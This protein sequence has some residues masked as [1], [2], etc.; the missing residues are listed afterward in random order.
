MG[1]WKREKVKSIIYFAKSLD[2]FALMKIGDMTLIKKLAYQSSSSKR[3]HSAHNLVTHTQIKGYHKHLK[4]GAGYLT[5]RSK[6]SC[7]LNTLQYKFN[8][9]M[10][11]YFIGLLR[12]SMS[13]LSGQSNIFF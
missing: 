5:I 2:V 13:L 4:S 12:A 10:Q 9:F 7:W 1:G 11:E 3:C 6:I 8:T